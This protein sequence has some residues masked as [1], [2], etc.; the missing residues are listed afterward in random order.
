MHDDPP[1]P[2]PASDSSSSSG[3]ERRRLGTRIESRDISLSFDDGIVTERAEELIDL[4][5]ESTRTRYELHEKLGEGRLGEVFRAQDRRLGRTI[6]FKRIRESQEDATRFLLDF[7]HQTRA[8]A[9]LN[10][11]NIVQVYD[12][13]KDEQGHFIAMEYVAGHTL[14]ELIREHGPRPLRYALE[15]GRQLCNATAVAHRQEVLHGDIKPTNV[16]ISEAGVHKLADFGLAQIARDAAPGL[17]GGGGEQSPYIA[18]EVRQD[19]ANMDVRADVYSL[20]ATLHF[21]LTG[22]PPTEP[23]TAQLPPPIRPVLG[24]TLEADP[25]KRYGS[26]DELAGALQNILLTAP[27]EPEPAVASELVRCPQ[28]QT[29]IRSDVEF[30]GACG[31]ELR[32]ARAVDELVRRA[33]EALERREVEQALRHYEAILEISPE[34]DEATQAARSIRGKL[35]RIAQW[36][37][38][39]NDLTAMGALRKAINVWTDLLKL[40]PGDEEATAQIRKCEEQLQARQIVT[41]LTT[42]RADIRTHRFDA[43]EDKCQQVLRADPHNAEANAL[44]WLIPQSRQQWIQSLTKSAVEAYRARDFN[45]AYNRF[46]EAYA[47]AERLASPEEL[48]QLTEGMEMAR[49]VPALEEVHVHAAERPLV[50]SIAELNRLEEK[51]TT[52]RA[53]QVIQRSRAQIDE[54]YRLVMEAE[55]RRAEERA[56]AELRARRRQQRRI[57]LFVA[58]AAVVILGPYMLMRQ[59]HFW[60]LP[61]DAQEAYQSGQPLTALRLIDEYLGRGGNP[62]RVAGLQ[63]E[64]THDLRAQLRNNNTDDALRW[65]GVLAPLAGKQTS[66]ELLYSLAEANFDEALDGR[67]WSTALIALQQLARYNPTVADVRPEIAARAARLLDQLEALRTMSDQ[68]P[69]WSATLVALEHAATNGELAEFI[70]AELRTRLWLLQLDAALAEHDL[71]RARQYAAKLDRHDMQTYPGSARLRS[72][73]DQLPQR[74]AAAA[75][76]GNFAAARR[77]LWSGIDLRGNSD[78]EVRRQWEWLL[79]HALERRQW[80][81][82]QNTASDIDDIYPDHPGRERLVRERTALLEQA[83]QTVAGDESEDLE[84]LLTGV[85]TLPGPSD[86][87]FPLLDRLVQRAQTA[88]TWDRTFK[89]IA[90]LEKTSPGRGIGKPRFQN[91]LNHAIKLRDVERVRTVVG[92]LDDLL[93]DHGQDLLTHTLTYDVLGDLRRT[94]SSSDPRQRGHAVD[95]LV[96]LAPLLTWEA[97]AWRGFCDEWG[98]GVAEPLRRAYCAAVAAADPERIARLQA[99]NELLKA[100]FSCD[101]AGG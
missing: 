14:K 25:Q 7:V 15:L 41:L 100:D 6:A 90:A 16:L 70:T 80:D 17:A 4:L 66:K 75:S 96:E 42:A 1:H 12:I 51:A 94:L 26:V 32:R 97:R 85:L 59:L 23:L 50:D 67:T 33:R 22:Q 91:L 101:S 13:G 19:P 49:L 84:S 40:A 92:A 89:T 61:A 53:R 74:V 87:V 48:Q 20:G 78:L 47:A 57:A 11:F 3:D 69:D 52:S 10:H 35:E 39:A 9:N 5:E 31:F 24:K 99:L 18:P 54:Q 38:E 27:L 82:A 71:N 68:L 86:D 2:G 29:E 46:N 28:C 64:L 83:R 8:I 72:Y 81:A 76:D 73:T 79:D 95:D 77:E 34:H 36:R 56:A 55:R 60:G 43:A 44:R 98:P 62:R 88:E 63:E 65:A 45:T 30:C 93:A 58:A 37:K 21:V